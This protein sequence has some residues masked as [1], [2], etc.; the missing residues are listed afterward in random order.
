[1]PSAALSQ[2]NILARL[3]RPER[4]FVG[5][6]LVGLLACSPEPAAQPKAKSGPVRPMPEIKAKDWAAEYRQVKAASQDPSKIQEPELQALTARLRAVIERAKDPHLRANA[7]I[8]AAAMYDAKKAY[9]T[10]LSYYRQAIALVPQEPSGYALSAL[11]LAKLKRF[12]EAVKMQRELV[13]RDPD[14]LQGWL[15]L[16]EL[17]TR[18]NHPERAAK[19]YAA[20]ETRRSGLLEG[21][22]RKN[23]DGAYA[24]D[25]A[26]RR[27]CVHA[28]SAAPDAGTSLALVYALQSEPAASVRAAIIEV[29][30]EQRF[31]GYLKPLK[32]WKAKEQESKLVAQID[33]AIK[34]ISADPVKTRPEAS[35][36]AKPVEQPEAGAAKPAVG[37]GGKAAKK[38]AAGS[39]KP[40]H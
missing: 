37:D 16:G 29:M 30:H 2:L 33:A 32:E 3:V 4:T 35:D 14:D 19:A 26:H 31:A 18:A 13:R 34:A 20:Y 22:T 38:P 10:A 15:L 6:A 40:A 12:D 17:N 36:I 21:L 39:V 27:E 5:F 23:A 7:C 24:L 9:P 11:T 8:L 1:M 28:L 25:E